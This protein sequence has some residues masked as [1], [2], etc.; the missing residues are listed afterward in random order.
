MHHVACAVVLCE[1]IAGYKSSKVSLKFVLC[2]GWRRLTGSPK[3]QIIFHKRATKC[4]SLLQK[5][6]YKDK[7]SYESSPP[8]SRLHR[9]CLSR[10]S[11]DTE[12]FPLTNHL[13]QSFVRPLLKTI[14]PRLFWCQTIGYRI[15]FSLSSKFLDTVCFSFCSLIYRCFV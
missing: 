13:I 9:D 10:D 6:T 14:A 1:H 8:F 4:R 7:A 12:I 2:T 11:F 15:F 5:M 3:L